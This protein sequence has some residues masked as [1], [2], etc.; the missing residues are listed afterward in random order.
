MVENRNVKITTNSIVNF[1][2]MFPFGGLREPNIYHDLG[3][4]YKEVGF[5][6]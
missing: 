2:I 5:L 6:I 1:F 4:F 3:V